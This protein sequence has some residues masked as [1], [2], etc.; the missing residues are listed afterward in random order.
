[1]REL[2]EFE[3]FSLFWH[4]ALSHLTDEEIPTIQVNGRVCKTLCNARV[5]RDTEHLLLTLGCLDADL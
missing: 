4:Y 2:F 3:Y 5:E 1:M